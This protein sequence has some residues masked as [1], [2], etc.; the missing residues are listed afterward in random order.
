MKNYEERGNSPQ[1]GRD[2]SFSW[3][4]VT[5][6]FQKLREH[7]R[8]L[9]I[10]VPLFLLAAVGVYFIPEPEYTA[11]AIIG[12]PPPSPVNS[13]MSGIGGAGGS[14]SASL[15]KRVMGGGTPGS[16]DPFQEYLQMLQSVRLANVLIQKDHILP[17]LFPKRWDAKEH[18]WRAPGMIGSTLAAFNRMS[19]RPTGEV[20]NA[21]SVMKFFKKNLVIETANKTRG[22]QGSSFLSDTSYPSVSLTFTD[23]QKAQQILSIILLEAD[24]LI[25][26]DMQNDVSA[27]LHYLSS[28]VPTVTN[29]Y[30]RD[31][32]IDVLSEQEQ[33]QVMLKSDKRYAS[34]LIDPPYASDIPSF[35]PTLPTLFVGAFVAAL[36][37]WGL[38]VYLA[39]Q[40]RFIGRL[41]PRTQRAASPGKLAGARPA[42]DF[43][44]TP[45]T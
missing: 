8:L 40:F 17:T 34:T 9:Y 30:D 5:L 3:G 1:I 37:V 29:A 19:G 35:P 39:M 18:K 12:P 43:A 31:A 11:T 10:I 13:M 20:P 26:E 27:R 6:Y 44:R 38:L 7:R 21:D 41:L 32:L 25:R 15:L 22:T 45:G 2:S 4:S 42:G 23:P 24:N 36:V 16:N 28:E 14:A 33:M